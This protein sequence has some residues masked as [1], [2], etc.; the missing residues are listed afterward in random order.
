MAL[1]L[2]FLSVLFGLGACAAPYSWQETIITVRQLDRDT[3][4]EIC[5]NNGLRESV[6]GCYNKG[7]IYCPY[8]E[9]GIQTCLHEF[10]HALVGGFHQ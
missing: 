2:F 10:R 8:D 9:I 5:R 7:V 4:N 6:N 3:V 1:R